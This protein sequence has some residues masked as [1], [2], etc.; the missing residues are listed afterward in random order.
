M[1]RILKRIAAGVVIA[2]VAAL[3]LEAAGK[4]DVQDDDR[5]EVIKAVM[6]NSASN[7]PDDGS[8]PAKVWNKASGFGRLDALRAYQTLTAGRIEKCK[9]ACEQKGCAFFLA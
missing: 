1:S 6:V 2:G 9:T 3:L 8:A 5:S 4:T 7:Q